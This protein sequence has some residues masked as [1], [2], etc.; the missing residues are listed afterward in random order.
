MKRLLLVALCSAACVT[1]AQEGEQ[2]RQDIA[3]LRADLKKEMDATA[4][5]RQK[6]QQRAKALQDAL[7]ARKI[8]VRAQND[9]RGVRLSA[10]MYVS[11][12]D[13]DT[14]LEVVAG[15]R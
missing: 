10:H 12:A 5:D 2:M 4:A 9:A 8:R 11:P 13:V 7:W 1:T 15:L 14:V 3:A 6:D